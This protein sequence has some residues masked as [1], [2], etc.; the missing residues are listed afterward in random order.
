[1]GSANDGPPNAE[2]KDKTTQLF[3][4]SASGED[5]A[6]CNGAWLTADGTNSGATVVNNEEKEVA[7]FAASASA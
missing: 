3:L 2:D 5:D 4:S 7:C 6:D 1:M